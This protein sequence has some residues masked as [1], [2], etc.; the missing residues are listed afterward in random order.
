[1][2]LQGT[3][4]YGVACSGFVRFNIVWFSIVW[5]NMLCCCGMGGVVLYRWFGAILCSTMWYCVWCGIVWYS[6]VLYRWFCCDILWHTVVLYMTWDCVV[7]YMVW[8]C[9]WCGI[10]CGVGLCDKVWVLKAGLP[11]LQPSISVQ[12]EGIFFPLLDLAGV[13][14][15]AHCCAIFLCHMGR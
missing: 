8:Y 14:N 9:T 3:V 6:M 4:S 5:H 12:K 1:M 13:V 11:P 10:G 7:L 2:I 15:L